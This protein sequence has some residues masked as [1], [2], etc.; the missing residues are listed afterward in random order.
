MNL[1]M[2]KGFFMEENVNEVLHLNTSKDKLKIVS[3]TRATLTKL[4][5]EDKKHN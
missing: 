1:K 3:V 5:D 2:F 4:K